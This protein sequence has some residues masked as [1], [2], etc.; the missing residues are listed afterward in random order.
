VWYC[1]TPCSLSLVFPS[2][3]IYGETGI[4]A[5][6]VAGSALVCG[7]C[8]VLSHVRVLKHSALQSRVAG[9]LQTRVARGVFFPREFIAPDGCSYLYVSFLSMST[10]GLVVVGVIVRS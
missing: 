4:S 2:M 5:T 1:L 10:V 3:A 9:A 6:T 8:G 7:G